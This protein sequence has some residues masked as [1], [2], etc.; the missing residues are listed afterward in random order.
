MLEFQKLQLGML[1]TL[2]VSPHSI[3]M[4]ESFRNI[5]SSLAK[6]FT[7]RTADRTIAPHEVTES[8]IKRLNIDLVVDVGANEGQFVDLVRRRGFSKRIISIEPLEAAFNKLT[9]RLRH[10]SKWQGVRTALGEKTDTLTMEVAGNSFMSSSLLQ[11]LPNHVEAEPT[12]AIFR[13]ETVSVRRLDEVLPPL[14]NNEERIFLKVDTQG[15]EDHVLKGATGILG[16]IVLLE[17]ELSLVT[18]YSGQTLL[19]E[20]MNLVAGLGFTPVS[21]DRGFADN[22]RGK[23]LQ[24]DGLF[25]RNDLVSVDPV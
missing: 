10:D 2:K 21:L 12:S 7:R 16:K 5:V 11:M 14:L 25:V 19:P 22:K 8:W 17:L 1:Q 4:V 23:L 13:T 9:K 3:V 15:F 20:M 6:K 18:L 24:V